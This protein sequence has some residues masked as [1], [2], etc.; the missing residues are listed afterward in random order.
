MPIQVTRTL[1]TYDELPT[2]K[3]KAKARDWYREQDYGGDFVAELL[4]EDFANALADLG[5]PVDDIAWRFSCSQGDGMAF[6]GACDADI[7][8]ARLASDKNKELLLRKRDYIS[9]TIDRNSFGHH[10]SH[11]NTMSISISDVS[12]ELQ[13]EETSAAVTDLYEAI[14]DEVKATSKKL[15]D[16]AMETIAWYKS[17]ETVAENISANDWTFLE[18]GKQEDA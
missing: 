17:D 12:G 1:Y 15:A 4:E 14:V 7:L 5:Y 18:S 13:D 10:Y 6:Y 3:A 16:E 9:I 11:Y 2:E 8:V